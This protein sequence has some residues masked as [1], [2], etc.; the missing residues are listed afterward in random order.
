M[1]I[2]TVCPGCAERLSVPD[3]YA[4]R[5][6]KCPRCGTMVTFLPG[7]PPAAAPPAVLAAPA[8]P[9]AAYE[10]QATFSVPAYGA[11]GQPAPSGYPAPP[12]GPPRDNTELF[13]ILGVSGA[14]FFLAL[15]AISTFLRWISVGAPPPLNRSGVQFGDGRIIL[16]LSLVLAAA[17]GLNFLSRK[18]LPLSMVCAGAF[19]SFTFVVLL[20]HLGTFAGAGVFLG[21]FAAI[22]AMGT[23]IWTAVRLPL[24]LELPGAA[25]QPS[26]V[27]TFGA[28]LG[29]QTAAV[30]LA[31]FY[32]ILH[33]IL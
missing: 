20:A 27:R 18:F 16:L 23:T 7:G 24:L 8:P 25:A 19:A 11:A 3:E 10:P 5:Q 14:T 4:N 28:L 22:G 31:L 15:L 30:V 26:F 6:G 9:P 32:W 12:P 21:L 17:A 1:P 33:A 13:T 29:T 2:E